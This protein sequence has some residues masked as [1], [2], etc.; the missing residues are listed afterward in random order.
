MHVQN[1]SCLRLRQRSSVL[2]PKETP[3]DIIDLRPGSNLSSTLA[4][5]IPRGDAGGELDLAIMVRSTSLSQSDYPA[6]FRLRDNPIGGLVFSTA[7]SKLQ[8]SHDS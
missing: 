2:S 6:R 7:F 5:N 8:K 4:E 1:R 3:S